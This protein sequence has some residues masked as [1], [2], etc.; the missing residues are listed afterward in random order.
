MEKL[1]EKGSFARSPGH[2]PGAPRRQGGF[3]NFYVIFSYVPFLLPSVVRP[4]NLPF[5][6]CFQARMKFSCEK[7]GKI[8]RPSENYFSIF[9]SLGTLSENLSR[10]LLT[11]KGYFKFSGYFKQPRKMP[12]KMRVKWPFSGLFF[13]FEVILTS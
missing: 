7:H 1:A 3:Q 2:Q 6:S 13:D 10:V 11:P 8:K 5:L 9:W 4:R 12:C